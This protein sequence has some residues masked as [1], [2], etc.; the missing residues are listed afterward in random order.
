[1]A[2]RTRRSAVSTVMD[3][4]S[5]DAAKE[6]RM[7][8]SAAAIHCPMAT[9]G[10]AEMGCQLF[11]PSPAVGAFQAGWWPPDQARQREGSS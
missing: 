6:R 1:M 5:K 11:R 10:K 9:L 7:T 8:A 2:V 3:W 4:S